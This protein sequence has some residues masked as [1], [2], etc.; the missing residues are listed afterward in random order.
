MTA[1]VAGLLFAALLIV[2]TARA[3]RA[4]CRTFIDNRGGR[5]AYVVRQKEPVDLYAYVGLPNDMRDE[6][7][8]SFEWTLDQAGASVVVDAGHPGHAT[9]FPGLQRKLYGLTIV[10]TSSAKERC[11]PAT[12]QIIVDLDYEQFVA[13]DQWTGSAHDEL[14]PGTPLRS[15]SGELRAT[16]EFSQ[17][18]LPMY[19]GV[20]ASRLTYQHPANAP[21]GKCPASDPGCVTVVA[22]AFYGPR[23]AGQQYVPA[24]TISESIVDLRFGIK[25]L[26]PRIYLGAAYVNRA[27]NAPNHGNLHGV[28]FVIDKLPDLD[29][30][31][32]LLGS[33]AY[34]PS[35]SGVWRAA[36]GRRFNVTYTYARY[37]IGGAYVFFPGKYF[38]EGGVA[39]DRGSARSNAPADFTRSET[40]IGLGARL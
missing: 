38:L 22:P 40:F 3:A 23:G 15:P 27:W 20:A 11:S 9:F 30:R 4:E 7:P 8:K 18:S 25:A 24:A 34:A 12:L 21:S 36:D 16:M 13:I 14:T 19:L 37:R 2:A 35:A 29:Q 6:K 39:E 5:L 31:F 17:L 1:R 10:A 26:D 32:T 33:F 28:A